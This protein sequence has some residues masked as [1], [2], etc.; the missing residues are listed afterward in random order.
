MEKYG[1]VPETLG[2]L[3]VIIENDADK[4]AVRLLEKRLKANA[5][6]EMPEGRMKAR[7]DGEMPEGRENDLVLRLDKDGLALTGNGQLLRGDFT[8]MQPRIHPGNLSRE[9]LVKAAKIKGETGELTAV[10]ATAGLGED[11]FL[12]AAAG[13]SVK[14]YEYDPVIAALLRDALY[15]ASKIAGLAAIAG[16][17]Q[18]FEADSQTALTH[19][20]TSPAVILLDPMFP[21]RQKSGLI[22][23]KFQLLQQ[24]ERPCPDAD[25]DALLYAALAAHPRKVVIKRPFK[26]PYLAGRKPD[27]SL[28]GKAIRYDCIVLPPVCKIP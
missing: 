18:L 5:E 11:A 17:M 21:A 6:G 16:R 28:K 2:D 26:G 15:R 22:K 20:E 25:A 3:A 12:L 4:E 9:L 8:K 23:K 10:D 13:F 27:Y 1:G 14:L 19:L 24:L 7:P